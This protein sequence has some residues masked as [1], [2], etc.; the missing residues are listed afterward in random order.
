MKTGIYTIQNIVTGKLYIGCAVDIKKRW[1]THKLRLTKGVHE[2]S[3][4]QNAWNKYGKDNFLFEILEECEEQFLY[5]LEHY[6]CNL[7]DINNTGYNIRPTSPNGKAGISQETKTKISESRIGHSWN[8]GSK[9]NPEAKQRQSEMAK[10]RGVSDKCR[11]AQREKLINGH[12][13]KLRTINLGS[14]RSLE[15]I[16]VM[17]RKATG[18]K[19][20]QETI[21]KKIAKQKGKKRTPEQIENIKMGI[22][23]K[24]L[25]QF[26]N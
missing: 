21:N 4:L 25:Q 16:E 2:N 15:S 20:S 5:S 11:A 26:S 17:R 13:E 14:K 22:R 9:W 3:Y 1:K 19:Q 23:K 7:L 6:W 12:S 18:K 24:K 10:R 8:K